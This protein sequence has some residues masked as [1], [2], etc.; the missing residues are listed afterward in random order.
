MPFGKSKE[1]YSSKRVLQHLIFCLQTKNCV[2]YKN[3]LRAQ[4]CFAGCGLLRTGLIRKIEFTKCDGKW[5]S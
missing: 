5:E 1:R 3:W 4:L 2:I